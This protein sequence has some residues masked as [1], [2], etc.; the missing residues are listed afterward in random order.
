MMMNCF[1]VFHQH[2]TRGRGEPMCILVHAQSRFA[3]MTARELHAFRVG[4]TSKIFDE[5]L[6]NIDEIPFAARDH[7]LFTDSVMSRAVS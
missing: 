3:P 6:K 7:I 1:H 5:S 4:A 2:A